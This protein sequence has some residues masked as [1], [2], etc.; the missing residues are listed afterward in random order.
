MRRMKEQKETLGLGIKKK[1]EEERKIFWIH[2]VAQSRIILAAIISAVLSHSKR[3]ILKRQQR[4]TI[5]LSC[6]ENS[7]HR[8]REKKNT[9]FPSVI[10]P[11]FS[12]SQCSILSKR[13]K[14]ETELREAN[15]FYFLRE[16]AFSLVPTVF[17][18]RRLSIV[19]LE[20]GFR[21]QKKVV[22]FGG[23]RISITGNGACN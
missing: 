14:T 10:R 4:M 6:R 15:R 7:F 11:E 3:K 21:S 13:N 22:F 12:H 17:R 19:G 18:V 1:N 5:F 8:E 23:V 16:I 20:F 9:N 2:Q